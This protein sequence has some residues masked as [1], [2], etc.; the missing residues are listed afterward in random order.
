MS[1][2]HNTPEFWE[3][4]YRAGPRRWELGGATPVFRRLAESG[5]F[6]PGRMIIPGA[7][8]GDDG[9]LFARHGFQVTAVDFAPTAAR[10]MHARQDPAEPL[11]ILQADWFDLP[12][13]LN[14][15]FDYVLEYVFIAA[16]DPA[17]RAAF[18]DVVAALLRPGGAFIGLLWPIGTHSS[19]PPF[20]V[21]PDDVIALLADRGLSLL[22]RERPPD[23]VPWRQG[24]EELVVMARGNYPSA[25]PTTISRSLS[26]SKREPS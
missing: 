5:E 18:A 9:R 25:S 16:I 6:A 3:A 8:L 10:A 14:G 2:E 13:R 17:Q 20:A 23:S 12:P 11:V 26:S 21:Q 19:G 24:K 4:N 15:V 1:S 22:R 7:G